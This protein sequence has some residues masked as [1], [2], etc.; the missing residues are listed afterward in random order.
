[1]ENETAERTPI[2]DIAWTRFA[3]LD[4]SAIKRTR[5]FYRIRKIIL[6]L[7]VVATLFA[8]LTT[9]FFKDREDLLSLIVNIFFISTPIIASIF[10]A[11]AS[12]FYSNGAWLVMRAG[13]EEIKKEIYLYRTRRRND[14]NRHVKLEKNLA[15]IQRQMYRSLNGEF[16]YEEYTGPIPPYYYPGEEKQENR[17]DPGYNNLTGDQY[18]ALR[19]KDQL[20]WHNRKI[21]GYKLQRR[22]TAI[23][24]LVMGGLGALLAALG[25]GLAIWVALT[26]SITAALIGWQ[27]LINLDTIIRNYS[28]IVVELSILSD[29]W[30]NLELEQRTDA[31]FDKLVDECEAVLWA[32]NAEYI[33][34]MQEVLK[35]NDLSEEASLIEGVIDKAVETAQAAQQEMRDAAL[36]FASETMESSKEQLVEEFKATLG[37]LAEEASSELVQQELAAMRAAI[38]DAVQSVTGEDKNSLF[39]AI[40]GIA[41]QFSNTEIG[42]DTT[43]EELNKILAEYPRTGEVKG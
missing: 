11:F 14:P 37:T 4:A 30:R 38:G 10:A 22:M 12:R 40:A 34:S 27:E 13:A 29:H 42:R 17:G 41:K 6:W 2:L 23:Y 18:F 32:Q 7:G 28:K 25:Q 31:E 26:S 9:A 21:N 35:E 33:R 15:G 16:S 1:M 36:A 5:G 8:I 24:I 19:V 43:K 3:Q 39:A 20:D